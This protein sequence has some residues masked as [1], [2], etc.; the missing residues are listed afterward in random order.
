MLS[1]DQAV[2]VIKQNLPNGK[3]Q[4]AV[5]YKDL[6]LFVVYNDLPGEEEMDPFFSVNKATGAF[7]DFSVITD[8]NTTEIF[9]L[10]ETEALL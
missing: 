4:N 8:G 5:L 2:K 3:I 10:F 1:F 6:F 7:S 9:K